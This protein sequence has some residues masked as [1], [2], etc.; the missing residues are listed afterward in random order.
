[1]FKNLKKIFFAKNVFLPY[2]EIKLL[3][4]VHSFLPF[5]FVIWQVVC[6]YIYSLKHFIDIIILDL[7]REK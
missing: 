2:N 1:M 6:G 7:F 4:C 3:K 5:S